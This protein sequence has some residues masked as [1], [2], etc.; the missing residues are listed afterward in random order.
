MGKK[1]WV[2]ST[3]KKREAGRDERRKTNCKDIDVGPDKTRGQCIF[4]GH[5]FSSVLYHIAG[6]GLSEGFIHAFLL[7]LEFFI[8]SMSYL[9]II[10]NVLV[11]SWVWQIPFFV[12][13]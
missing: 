7:I 12:E 8:S 9:V 11:C 6:L 4:C 13:F 3:N 2:G 1:D 5:V 10:Y